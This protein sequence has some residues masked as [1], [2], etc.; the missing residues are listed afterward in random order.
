MYVAAKTRKDT[1]SATNKLKLLSRSWE[2]KGSK[3]SDKTVRFWTITTDRMIREIKGKKPQRPVVCEASDP[4]KTA[5]RQ[6]RYQQEMRERWFTA[7]REQRKGKSDILSIYG[8]EYKKSEEGS[9]AKT[10]RESDRRT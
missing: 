10:K 4:I 5:H 6:G 9:A 3:S 8:R 7:A 1:A 2:T